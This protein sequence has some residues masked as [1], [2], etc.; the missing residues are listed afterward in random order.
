VCALCDVNSILAYSIIGYRVSN[1]QSPTNNNPPNHFSHWFVSSL[2]A[3]NT[4][5]PPA[6]ALRAGRLKSLNEDKTLDA[7]EAGFERLRMSRL[8]ALCGKRA[9]EKLPPNGRGWDLA[10]YTMT[11]LLVHVFILMFVV[12]CHGNVVVG[13]CSCS[14]LV[15][16]DD[17]L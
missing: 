2:A 17:W 12:S 9:G 1:S 13:V 7:M 10:S 4:L 5:V 3:R 8:R 11:C 6:K 15:I 14:C 16:D